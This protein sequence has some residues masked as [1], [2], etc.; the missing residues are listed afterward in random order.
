MAKNHE[1]IFKMTL[2][3]HKKVDQVEM[4]ILGLKCLKRVK[5]L[6]PGNWRT[7]LNKDFVPHLETKMDLRKTGDAFEA[8]VEFYA[9]GSDPIRKVWWLA[10]AH[11]L[12]TTYELPFDQLP[13]SKLEKQK[14]SI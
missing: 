4:E 8:V 1:K 14:R 11:F 7:I 3:P 5:E 10:A 2:G 12:N 13:E 6:N 9:Q